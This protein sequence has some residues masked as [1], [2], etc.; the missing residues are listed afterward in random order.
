MNNSWEDKLVKLLLQKRIGKKDE[1]EH[2][3]REYRD[4]IN[5]LTFS[6]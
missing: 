1:N 4:N 2:N 3:L 6:L 5:A